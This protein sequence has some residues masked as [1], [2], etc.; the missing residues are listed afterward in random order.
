[1]TLHA[2]YHLPSDNQKSLPRLPVPPLSESLQKY[3]ISLKPLLYEEA[4][5][6][7]KSDPEAF[8]NAEIEKRKA[9]ARDFDDAKGLGRILQERLLDL[10]RT[11]PTNWL[12]DNFW[13]KLA[14]HSWRVPLPV[15][16][17]W[18]IN[19]AHDPDAPRAITD[20]HPPEGE[21]TNWQVRRA[22]NL[23][24]RLLDFKDRLDRCA[25]YGSLNLLPHPD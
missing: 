19:C 22:A 16:S 2:D 20:S 15:N 11:S 12:D 4:R 13:T 25:D 1:M 5:L 9:L 21:F 23:A 24:W 8:V 10:E 18:W 3:I 6:S 7:S 17:N 14:Y